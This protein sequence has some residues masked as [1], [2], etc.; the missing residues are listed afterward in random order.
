[1][2]VMETTAGTESWPHFGED[3]IEAAAAVLRSGRVNQWT[4]DRVSAFEKACAERFGMPY[5]IALA[6]G[7]LALELALRAFDIGPGDEVIV[8]PASFVA[9]ASCVSLMGARPVFADV[10][11][12]SQNISAATV[13]PHITERTRAII[14]VHLAGCPVDMEPMMALAAKHDLIVIED[15]AQAHGA[16]IAGKPIGSF[17][18]AAAFS[19]CQDKIM[20]TGGEGGML[21]CRDEDIYS[22]AWSWKDHGKRWEKTPHP[23]PQGGFHYRHDGLGSNWRLTEMQAAIGLVQLGKLDAWLEKR[24][25]NAAIWSRALGQ[26][27][28]IRL[29]E[30]PPEATHACYK[31]CVFLVPGHLKPD[32]SRDDVVAALQAAGIDAGAGFCPEIYLEKAFAELNVE[33]R[34]VAHELGQTSLMFKVHPTLDPDKLEATAQRARDVIAD[35]E[36]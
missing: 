20:T 22:R 9:S 12:N 7:T 28:A 23:A 32:A 27:P 1:M 2:T 4:G 15:C 10:E 30:T 8:T 17:G 21:L 36:R 16:A 29:T 14:P 11:R 31:Y 34:P 33:R 3:E 19:F 5:A 24:H 25:A 35:F 6:N 18:H 26:S 13:L